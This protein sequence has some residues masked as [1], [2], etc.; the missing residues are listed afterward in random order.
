LQIF[1]P[2]G[3]GRILDFSIGSGLGTIIGP[4]IFARPRIFPSENRSTNG[5]IVRIEKSLA[6]VY[7]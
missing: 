5:R 1:N 4:T 2:Q 3:P 6:I 7:E